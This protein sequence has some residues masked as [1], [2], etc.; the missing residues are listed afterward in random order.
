MTILHFVQS[1]LS[2]RFPRSIGISDVL[3]FLFL[4]FPRSIGRTEFSLRLTNNLLGHRLPRS[5]CNG[6]RGLDWLGRIK[7][8]CFSKWLL[9]EFPDWSMFNCRILIFSFTPIEIVPQR[10]LRWWTKR[11]IISFIKFLHF[12]IFQL[13]QCNLLEVFLER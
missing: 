7:M 10:D 4:G 6:F 13:S 9:N 11:P 1:F 12:F 8:K 3:S 2:I 5:I